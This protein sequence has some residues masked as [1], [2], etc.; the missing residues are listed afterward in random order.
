MRTKTGAAE[1]ELIVDNGA[2]DPAPE[3]S[4]T[5]P[6]LD[7]VTSAEDTFPARPV[8]GVVKRAMDFALALTTIVFLSPVLLFL[9]A[10]VRLSSSGPVIFRQ[11]RGGFAGRS[12]EIFKFRSMTVQENGP[13]VVQATEGDVRVTRF[14]KFLR[15]TSLDELPQ[16]FNVLNGDMSLIGPRPHALAHDHAF[17][18]RAPNY[19]RRQHARP[20]ITGLAQ[21]WGCRGEIKTDDDLEQRLKHDIDYIERW[22]VR[23]DISIL[24]RTVLVVPFDKRAY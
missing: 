17:A 12:F 16:L 22:S 11:N 15:G 23:L 6:D 1:L 3:G 9:W 18:A 19:T 24:V 7:V 5:S 14:G 10:G 21:V 13:T 4:E 2:N 8:G 20:G